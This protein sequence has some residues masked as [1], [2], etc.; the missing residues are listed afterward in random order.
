MSKKNKQFILL[1]IIII[2]L[3]KSVFTINDL[4]N[5]KEKEFADEGHQ[6][7]LQAATMLELWIDDQVRLAQQIALNNDIVTLCLHPKDETSRTR[8]T[9][10]LNQL[11]KSYPYYENLPI[12]I[13]TKSPIN[14]QMDNHTLTVDNGE[15]IVDTVRHETIGKG[16]VNFSYINNIFSGK[17]YYVSEIYRSIWRENPIFVVSAPIKF[18]S[19]VIGVALVSPQVDYFT[20]FFVDSIKLGDTG[21][22]FLLDSSG[23][24]IAHPNRSLILN[25]TRDNPITKH[26]INQINTGNNFFEAKL[27]DNE[28]YY[29]GQKLN[30]DSNHIERDLYLV[31]TQNKSEYLSP[32]YK[33]SAFSILSL[34]ITSA[35]LYFLFILFNKLNSKLFLEE[36]LI[37]TNMELEEQV[38]KRTQQLEDMANRD[39]LTKLFNHRYINN[40]LKEI[41]FSANTST[42]L[43][44]AI[45][46]IDNF[47]MVNDQYGHQIGDEVLIKTT[48][49]I[50]NQ[51]LTNCLLGRYGGEEFLLILEHHTYEESIKL[52]EVIRKKIA[53]TR[54]DP[55]A[56][57]IT[58][59]IGLSYWNND[60]SYSLI[61]RAD[62]LMYQA[63]AS[64]KNLVIHD[65]INS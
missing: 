57:S 22:M 11:H 43:A 9:N 55:V 62:D 17:S 64:G 21:Y 48:K 7:T 30:F 44:V 33:F 47:K 5:T 26:I 61:K 13:K 40:H 15:F 39:S 65:P 36:H 50:C 10:Y 4:L 41:I 16:G 29:Y 54:F 14:I 34:L 59:S 6:L 25:D 56:H 12:A 1:S 24:T 28:K 8:A 63:K 51:L 58:V 49:T 31:V 20:Q 42:K 60:T 38:K 27:L 35:A 37:K 19:E 23:A 53:Q 45:I 52:V 32:V 3:I 46:D 2:L 18:N